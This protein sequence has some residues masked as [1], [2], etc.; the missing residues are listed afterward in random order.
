MPAKRLR[1]ALGRAGNRQ[2]KREE[3]DSLNHCAHLF[4]D[5]SLDLWR[6]L[7]LSRRFHSDGSL[8]IELPELGV[9]IIRPSSRLNELGKLEVE[10]VRLTN[11]Q[12]GIVLDLFEFEGHRRA[13]LLVNVVAYHRVHSL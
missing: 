11:R 13:R 7:R 6:Q 4:H 1:T 10:I 2:I 9:P 12:P 5:A 3:V 8:N